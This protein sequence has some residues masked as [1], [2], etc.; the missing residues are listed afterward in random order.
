M[1]D[2]SSTA[3]PAWFRLWRGAMQ[4]AAFCCASSLVSV[5]PLLLLPADPN[6]STDKLLVLIVG[7]SLLLFFLLLG[8]GVA[9]G[10]IA[11]LLVLRAVF[12]RQ[13]HWTQIRWPIIQLLGWSVGGIIGITLAGPA[14][15]RVYTQPV[16]IECSFRVKIVAYVDQNQNGLRDMTEPGIANV[17]VT[18]TVGTKSLDPIHT[19]K[20]GLAEAKAYAFLCE[21]GISEQVSAEVGPVGDYHLLSTSPLNSFGVTAYPNEPPEQVWYVDFIAQ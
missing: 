6:V 8:V 16:P 18:V 3:T 17:P 9:V 14:I 4:V 12:Q 11:I 21:H 10:V 19:D 2:K 20:A 1:S 13:V 15:G 7:N 5:T